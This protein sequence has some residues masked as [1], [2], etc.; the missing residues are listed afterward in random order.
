MASLWKNP[1]LRRQRVRLRRPFQIMAAPLMI[2][3]LKLVLKTSSIVA[4]PPDY[5]ARGHKLH[6][7]IIA[8]WHG[9]FF[10]LP[11]I[12]PREI[13][14]RAI[15]ARHDD[16]EAL[17]RVL[18][19]F[20][21]GLVRGAGAAGRVGGRDR[22]GAEAAHGLIASLREGFSIAL[23]GDIPPG[24]ARKCGLGIVLISSRSGRPI[25]PFAV[26]SSRYRSVNS[27]SRMT[28][29]LPFSKIGIAMG[30]PIY[31]PA[32]ASPEVLDTYRRQVEAAL[33]ATTAKAYALAGA[34]MTR[35]TPVPKLRPSLPSTP[36]S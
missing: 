13:P 12:Y 17:A 9:Q 32:D 3:Y 30:D 19:H 34:D 10:L 25:V 11:V 15:V 14:G 29:N 22:G 24:P 35:A 26:A 31:V 16:A 1:W 20:G 21:L 8:L 28:I 4:D 6:P 27:W 33:N 18:R 36:K 23:T 7:Q 2:N 5:V